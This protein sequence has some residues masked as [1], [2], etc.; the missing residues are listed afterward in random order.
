MTRLSCIGFTFALGILVV[1]LRISVVVQFDRAIFL[2]IVESGRVVSI[3]DGPGLIV[4]A[5]DAMQLVAVLE[6]GGG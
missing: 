6:C 3:G 5:H 2:F 4:V 1:Q